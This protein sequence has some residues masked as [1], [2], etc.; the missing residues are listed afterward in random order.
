MRPYDFI[1]SVGWILFILVA[2]LIVLSIKMIVL[3]DFVVRKIRL[4]LDIVAFIIG[5]IFYPSKTQY[6]APITSNLL[7]EPAT[8]LAVKIKTGKVSIKVNMIV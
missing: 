8:R 4:F 1:I 6:L 2:I 7:L 5:A 3:V